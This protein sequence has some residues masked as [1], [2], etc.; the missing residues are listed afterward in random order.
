MNRQF[1]V[2]PIRIPDGPRLCR[3]R[4]FHETKKY[5]HHLA[6]IMDSWYKKHNDE[7]HIRIQQLQDVNHRQH[8]DKAE[9]QRRL[10]RTELNL[11]HQ[12][13]LSDALLQGIT[14]FCAT[15]DRST[16]GFLMEKLTYSCRDH[17][18]RLGDYIDDE[19][20]TDDEFEIEMETLLEEV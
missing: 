18:L 17:G 6:E 15:V 13:D 7:L 9:L 4:V 1:N 11:E 10:R 16:A 19:D 8:G 14:E 20:E 5:D 12:N 3:P 2:S